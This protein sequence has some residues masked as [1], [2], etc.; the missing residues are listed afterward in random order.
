MALLGL[1]GKVSWLIL[2]YCK[3][4]HH[5]SS[6]PESLGSTLLLV[7]LSMR[8][9]VYPSLRSGPCLWLALCNRL[10]QK[11]HWKVQNKGFEWCCVIPFSLIWLSHHRKMTGLN[12]REDPVEI[13]PVFPTALPVDHSEPR[14]D[15]PSFPR[16]ELPCLHVCRSLI[17]PS[18]LG[19]VLKIDCILHGH[20]SKW[21]TRQ[22]RNFLMGPT[23]L[24][25][26]VTKV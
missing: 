10:R 8:G 2:M 24:Q 13:N 26:W 12:H 16:P 18:F 19:L 21:R 20:V 11:Q 4:S 6:L 3:G 22:L 1:T 7:I 9:A 17:F 5:S 23:N 14:Q 25:K 15:Q